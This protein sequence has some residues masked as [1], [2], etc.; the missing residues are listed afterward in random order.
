[1][2]RRKFSFCSFSFRVFHLAN[3]L[4][5]SGVMVSASK[6]DVRPA[7]ENSL[8]KFMTF[9]RGK[10]QVIKC[11][12]MFRFLYAHDWFL[13]REFRS[14]FVYISR[15]I[16]DYCSVSFAVLS[17]H[18]RRQYSCQS[19]FIAIGTSDEKIH[20]QCH[21]PTESNCVERTPERE[22]TFQ[23][24]V[25]RRQEQQKI[26]SLVQ[27]ELTQCCKQFYIKCDIFGL[28]AVLKENL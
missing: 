1:M 20:R 2:R 15:E 26:I 11:V 13:V 18:K 28:H 27:C 12:A 16:P 24:S 23:N 10:L 25:S 17:H 8:I 21:V 7:S 9:N 14:N 19:E 22:A 5:S 4:R 6:H 3:A